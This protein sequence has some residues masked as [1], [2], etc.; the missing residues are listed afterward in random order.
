[1]NSDEKKYGGTGVEIP[2]ELK[3]T[4]G[5]WDN[6]PYSVGFTLPPFGAVILKF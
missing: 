3:A 2:K 4:A 5:E 6:M 1:M